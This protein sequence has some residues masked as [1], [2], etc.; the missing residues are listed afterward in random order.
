M[1]TVEKTTH[2]AG[3]WMYRQ[4]PTSINTPEGERENWPFHIDMQGT[5]GRMNWGILIAKCWGHVS[6]SAE[7]NAR[8]I[9]AAPDL[10]EACKAALSRLAHNASC[11]SVRPTEEW[12]ERGSVS[13][14]EC[15]CE[16]RLVRAAI[17]KAEPQA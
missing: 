7:A 1:K 14:G 6:E 12:A 17:A 2:T 16:I 3:P 4:P 15:D 13:F 10:L 11:C 5:P 8:L 9:A